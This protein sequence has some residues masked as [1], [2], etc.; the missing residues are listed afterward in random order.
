MAADYGATSY[1]GILGFKPSYELNVQDIDKAYRDLQRLLHPDVFA[2]AAPEVLELAQQH[3][4]RAN[5]AA[6]VLRS[7][8]LRGHH[9]LEL[10]GV[11]A[12]AE[13]QRIEDMEMMMEVMEVSEELEEAAT[14]EAVDALAEANHGKMRG[15]EA[16]IS[17]ALRDDATDEVRRL[18]ESLQMYTRLDE[19]M[20]DW[21]P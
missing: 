19:K 6:K 5:E 4:A 20:R 14:Q 10:K 8:L 1:F 3:S 12:L 13:D 18:L 16:D 17:K 21:R 9:I 2:Q 11:K 7:A 15:V